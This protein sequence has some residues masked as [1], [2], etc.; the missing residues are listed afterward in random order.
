M[1]KIKDLEKEMDKFRAERD[2]RE[3]ELYT[4]NA[5]LQA[6]KSRLEHDLFQ[7]SKGQGGVPNG[8]LNADKADRNSKPN[9]NPNP[10]S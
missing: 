9:L 10:R 4:K 5:E 2:I 1:N 3:G 7:A 6:D 8:K